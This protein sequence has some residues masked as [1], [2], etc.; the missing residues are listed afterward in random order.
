MQGSGTTA[1]WQKWQWRSGKIALDLL[2]CPYILAGQRREFEMTVS[3]KKAG[4]EYR[5]EV[6]AK[7]FFKVD[8]PEAYEVSVT[9][10]PHVRFIVPVI[11]CKAI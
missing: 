8:A 9:A 1:S 4:K 10:L 7:G 5:G 3:F 2:Y 11:E 6:V